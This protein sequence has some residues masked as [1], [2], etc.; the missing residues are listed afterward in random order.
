MGASEQSE[1]S[2]GRIGVRM[3]LAFL[4]VLDRCVVRED[5]CIGWEG[6]HDSHGY[7]HLTRKEEDGK[8]SYRVFRVLYEAFVGP[9]PDGLQLHHR[10]ENKWCVNPLHGRPVSQREHSAL[11]SK[12][13]RTH[14]S[15]GHLMDEENTVVHR[16]SSRAS[17]VRFF[18]RKCRQIEYSDPEY[19][20]T[21]ARAMRERRA[22]LRA[23]AA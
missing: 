13:R 11:H 7:P 8:H 15:S 2:L 21:R 9:I 4:G 19:K 23:A 10:C 22:R 1:T 16:R 3:M 14:C 18:C 6:A 20:A 17:G 12:P 5:G